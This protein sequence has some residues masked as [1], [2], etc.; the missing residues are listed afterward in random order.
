MSDRIAH[1]FLQRRLERVEAQT[2]FRTELNGL[3][4]CEIVRS[5]YGRMAD[6][7]RRGV[8]LALDQDQRAV[9]S[10]E[11]AQV[12]EPVRKRTVTHR[13]AVFLI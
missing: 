3:K 11:S 5:V 10:A 8:A 13:K 12:I 6:P 4:R 7:L 9:H 1:G 2:G